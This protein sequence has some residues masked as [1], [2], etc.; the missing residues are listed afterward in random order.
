MPDHRNLPTL[1]TAILIVALTASVAPAAAGPDADRLRAGVEAGGAEAIALYRELLRY[2]NDALFPDDMEAVIAWLHEAF[3]ARGFETAELET[4]GVP[5]VLAEHEV[6][7]AE[8]TVL[9][10]LQA[11]GQPVD[12]SAWDQES[13]WEPALKERSEDGAWRRLPWS[14]ASCPL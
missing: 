3:A 14:R 11:D 7:G 1:V 5:L 13:P 9:V 4:G 2:P 10:Y 12:P 8:R 6:A